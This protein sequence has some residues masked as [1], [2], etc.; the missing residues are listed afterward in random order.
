M[1]MRADG[2]R[3]PVLKDGIPGRNFR[4]NDPKNLGALWE[5]IAPAGTPAISDA[6]SFR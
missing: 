2:A 6:S 3:R 4:R 5:E 1:I